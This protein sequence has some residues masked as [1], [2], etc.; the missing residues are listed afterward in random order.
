[1]RFSLPKLFQIVL[2]LTFFLFPGSLTAQESQGTQPPAAATEQPPAVPELAD[3]IPLATALSDRLASL[4][5]TIADQGALSRLEQQLGEISAVVDEYDKQFLVLKASTG[6]RAGQLPQ[7][8]AEIKSAGDTL[9][10]VSESVTAKVRSLGTLRKAWLAE[11]QQWNAWQAAL[12]KDEPLEEITATVTK[13]QGAIDTALGLLRQRLKPL[14]ALQEQVGTLQTRINT[15]TAEVEGLI[16]LTQGGVLVDA[17]P[18]MLSTHYVSQLAPALRDGVQTG[19][20]Q[21]L[22]PGQAFF[23]QAGR[24]RYP[25]GGALARASARLRPSSATV[26]ASRTLAVCRQ[27]AD[28]R[29]PLG[30]RSVRRRIL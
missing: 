3:L 22:W 1:M 27:T 16:S 21:I 20:A 6:P 9:T 23:A 7:L 18:A 15:L 30:G 29:G 28:C 8:K 2:L 14:L 11:Q 4:E 19:L 10:E 25:P 13:A 26:G 12:L 5:K 17:S 24:D